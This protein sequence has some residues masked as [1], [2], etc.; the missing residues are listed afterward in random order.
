MVKWVD[1]KYT[2]ST[3]LN[4]FSKSNQKWKWEKRSIHNSNVNYT[5][6]GN[7]FTK[8]KHFQEEK[9]KSLLTLAGGN[10]V[11]ALDCATLLDDAQWLQ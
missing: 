1:I 7:A 5:I 9:C 10:S 3:S 8:A 4:H 6:L 2:K 11:S